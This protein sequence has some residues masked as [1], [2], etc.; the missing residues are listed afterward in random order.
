MNHLWAATNRDRP[1]ALKEAHRILRKGGRFMCLEFSRVTLP[2][3]AALYDAYS[4]AVIPALGAAV[5]NDR[6][7]YQYLVESIKRFPD[8][9]AF[10]DL[11]AGAGF[12]DGV[13]GGGCGHGSRRLR[14]AD[15]CGG[16]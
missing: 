12:D 14:C 13:G 3:L 11:I 15:R 5:A 4:F 7:S 9:G 6:E 8:Q 2:P 1:K 16:A 10:A